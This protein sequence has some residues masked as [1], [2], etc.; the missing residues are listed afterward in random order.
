MRWWPLLVLLIGITTFFVPV[1]FILQESAY[2]KPCDASL[3]RSQCP[4]CPQKGDIQWKPSL[5]QNFLGRM[6][7]PGIQV[8]LNRK[9]SC[10]RSGDAWLEK[11][12]ECEHVNRQICIN[13]GGS[14]NECESP[15]RHDLAS[16]KCITLCV[17]VCKFP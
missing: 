14:F 16:D 17:E 15:C 6:S 5:F 3:P 7:R 11:Y 8:E 1:P 9:E 12:Q 10:E 2:C 4:K 13:F